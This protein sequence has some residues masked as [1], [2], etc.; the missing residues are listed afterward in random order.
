MQKKLE[1][2]KAIF[3]AATYQDIVAA[4]LSINLSPGKLLAGELEVKRTSQTFKSGILFVAM[5]A[6]AGTTTIAYIGGGFISEHAGPISIV[7]GVLDMVI[8]YT[9]YANVIK[10]SARYFFLCLEIASLGYLGYAMTGFFGRGNANTAVEHK[11]SADLAVSK[12]HFTAVSTVQKTMKS[13]IDNAALVADVEQKRDGKG[14]VFEKAKLIAHMAVKPLN[15]PDTLSVIPQFKGLTEA[16]KW[17]QAQRQKIAEN[18]GNYDSEFESIKNTAQGTVESLNQAIAFSRSGQQVNNLQV[19]IGSLKPVA[20]TDAATSKISNDVLTPEDLKADGFQGVIGYLIDVLTI[21]LVIVLALLK[22]SNKNLEAVRDEEMRVVIESILSDMKI[23]KGPNPKH[24]SVDTQVDILQSIIDSEDL[25][26]YLKAYGCT[27]ANYAGFVNEYDQITAG[28]LEKSQWSLVDIMQ[29][30]EK[31]PSFVK[32]IRNAIT[33]TPSD[34]ITIKETVKDLQEFFNL[35]KPMQ[36]SFLTVIKRL[37][38]K[39]AFSVEDL[40]RFI[41]TLLL[42]GTVTPTLIENLEKSMEMFA[43][44]KRVKLL[45]NT[46]LRNVNTN[47]LNAIGN[48]ALTEDKLAQLISEWGSE[49]NDPLSEMVE[50]DF[51]KSYPGFISK[52]IST[53]GARTLRV[54]IQAFKEKSAEARGEISSKKL[55]VREDV[56][57]AKALIVADDLDGYNLYLRDSIKVEG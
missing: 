52:A 12:D 30:I 21:A 40:Q 37:Q 13:A 23:T 57:K 15:A 2:L 7:F 44:V 9:L 35:N 29:E 33:I 49:I 20:N 39:G 43:S 8:V 51:G 31:D 54:L 19:L 46:F 24:I 47:T 26:K 38:S 17:M 56:A 45:S 11:L 25:Q 10:G 16:N 41:S 50:S 6:I 1:A 32:N 48:A 42:G 4:L 5:L 3:N 14:V 55:V 34:W 28:H 27:F 22:D 53:G 36:A 18:I